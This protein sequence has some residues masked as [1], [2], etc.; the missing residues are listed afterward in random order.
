MKWKVA[1]DPRAEKQFSKPGRT[2]QQEIERYIARNLETT[3]DPRRFGKPF[4]SVKAKEVVGEGQ[5]GDWRA[6]GR[7]L[8]ARADPSVRV[9]A[10]RVLIAD[11][12]GEDVELGLD[13]GG[14]ADDLPDYHF[15]GFEVAGGGELR[16]KK[17]GC[18]I[19]SDRVKGLFC[20]GHF[21]GRSSAEGVPTAGG[22]DCREMGR[23]IMNCEV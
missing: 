8:P 11:G 19:V 21:R 18:Q 9:L 4:L 14:A 13:G 12:V 22:G 10:C 3:E 1:F 23:E 15:L 6:R 16:A 20:T 7:D 17:N 2:A 5:S